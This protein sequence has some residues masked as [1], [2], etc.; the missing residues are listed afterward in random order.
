MQRT[1]N[2]IALKKKAMATEEKLVMEAH[3]KADELARDGAEEDGSRRH[4]TRHRPVVN[5]VT[6]RNVLGTALDVRELETPR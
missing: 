1:S 6:N 2:R 5:L 4:H 3:E